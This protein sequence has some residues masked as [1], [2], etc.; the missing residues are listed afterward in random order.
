MMTIKKKV[1][2][3]K[4]VVKKK[5][6]PK[7]KVVKKKA[8]IKKRVVK[9]KTRTTTGTAR[10]KKKAPVKKKVRARARRLG[11]VPKY[12]L[13]H[14]AWDKNKI[15]EIVCE[16]LSTSAHG[17]DRICRE[18]N[19]LPTTAS[20]LSWLSEENKGGGGP[21]LD[22]YRAGKR[23]Q[24]DYMADETID[25][26]DNDVYEPLVID[27]EPVV[28]NGKVIKTITSAAVN[29]ARLRV[30]A[31]KWAASKLEPRKYG[32]KLELSGNPERPLSGMTEEQLI[33]R[34]KQ[35]EAKLLENG[36]D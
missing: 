4:K 26:A 5:V 30:D 25:I 12:H 3:K 36:P 32:D 29:H 8:P 6:A 14:Q 17:L 7:R 19:D 27:G 28:V 24:A 10:G 15:M 23:L 22:M 9:K 13:N 21:L 34:Q 35:L 31:R 16:R 2:P 18:D 1:P 33:A 11:P 20:I